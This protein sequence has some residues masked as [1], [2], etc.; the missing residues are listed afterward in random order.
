M[1]A[2]GK[3]CF[4]CGQ[5]LTEEDIRKILYWGETTGSDFGCAVFEKIN[6]PDDEAVAC[7]RCLRIAQLEAYKEQVIGVVIE[8]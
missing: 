3:P 4:K 6:Y 8:Q 2:E 1:S 7:W 5:L